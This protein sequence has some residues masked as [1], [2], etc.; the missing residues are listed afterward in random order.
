M[1]AI[2]IGNWLTLAVLVAGVP[3][4]LAAKPARQ[5]N[6][7]APPPLLVLA[8]TSFALTD[9]AVPPAASLQASSRALARDQAN[10]LPG[11]RGAQFSNITVGP[12]WTYQTSR[13]G[14]LFEM[15]ALGGGVV[16]DRPRLA[17]VAFAWQ[18]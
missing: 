12:S 9:G 13:S 4:A 10:Q 16:E 2:R 3:S 6:E 8:E 7:A 17:H 1:A 18:F 11:Q 5:A 14:P 15:G